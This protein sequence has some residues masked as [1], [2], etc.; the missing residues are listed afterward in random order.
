MPHDQLHN[1]VVFARR[2][3]GG[4]VVCLLTTRNDDIASRFAPGQNLSV[5]ELE[6]D[7]SVELLRAL[8]PEAWQTEPDAMRQLA[9]IAG[10]LPLVLELLG[11]YLSVSEHHRFPELLKQAMDTLADPQKRLGLLVTGADSY[12][13]NAE[14]LFT[15]FDRIV[16]FFLAEKPGELYV[17]GC[18]VPSDLPQEVRDK[19]VRLAR[20]LVGV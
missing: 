11:G 18:T 6:K 13:Q 20:T 17:G 19:A 2:Y 4:Q 7:P 5:P 1:G 3:R 14:G 8:A 16:D 15:T 12:E 9:Q 10:G